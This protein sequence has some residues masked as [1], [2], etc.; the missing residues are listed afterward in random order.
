M[1]HMFANV[2]EAQAR[3]DRAINDTMPYGDPAQG[4]LYTA[5]ASFG[6]VCYSHD[7]AT[8]FRAILEL[9]LWPQIQPVVGRLQW[10]ARNNDRERADATL[11]GCCP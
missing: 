6:S 2:I 4:T 1:D 10:E 8:V 5:L 9:G 7:V 11:P 3:L